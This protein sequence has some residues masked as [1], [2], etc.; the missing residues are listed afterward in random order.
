MS[1][2][3]QFSLTSSLKSSHEKFQCDE[4]FSKH[5]VKYVKE[6]ADPTYAVLSKKGGRVA[7]YRFVTFMFIAQKV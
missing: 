3:E 1:S 2:V 4:C 7:L 5:K 6:L